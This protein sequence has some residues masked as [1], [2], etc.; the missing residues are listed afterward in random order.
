MK[1]MLGRLRVNIPS[2]PGQLGDRRSK[3]GL[4]DR[5]TDRQTTL[6]NVT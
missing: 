2:V 5:Q 3:R 4:K 6:D 1:G